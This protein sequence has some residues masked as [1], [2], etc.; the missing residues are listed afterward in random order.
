MFF[1][2]KSDISGGLSPDSLGIANAVCIVVPLILMEATPVGAI[3]KTVEF[4][5]LLIP[6]LKGFV[7][8]RYIKLTR[9]DLPAPTAPVRN[10]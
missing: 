7:K 1:F 8:V 3:N 2:F 4:S 9:C 5:G 6:C 10:K